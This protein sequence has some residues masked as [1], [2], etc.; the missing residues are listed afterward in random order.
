[1]PRGN[2]THVLMG[3]LLLQMLDLLL[4]LPKLLCCSLG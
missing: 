4:Q 2:T 3:I 1:M